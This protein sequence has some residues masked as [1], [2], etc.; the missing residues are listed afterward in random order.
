VRVKRP[1]G[2]TAIALLAAALT[3]GGCARDADSEQ[4]RVVTTR[5]LAAVGSGDGD[6][7][8]EQLSPNTRAKLEEQEQRQCR[9]A[10]TGLRLEPGSVAR[11]DVYALNA[12]VELSSGEA[13]FLEDGEEGWRLSAVGC[14]PQKDKPKDLPYDCRLED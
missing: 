1:R 13:A 2:P 9:E 12:F 11:V 7:A 14:T 4:A 3:A 6:V 8:C 10:V 5:F